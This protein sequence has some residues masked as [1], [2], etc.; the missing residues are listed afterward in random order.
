MRDPLKDLLDTGSLL[1]EPTD[2]ELLRLAMHSHGHISDKA[3][4]DEYNRLILLKIKQ[5]NS[6]WSRLFGS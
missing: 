2:H 6:L 5:R 4:I 3:A 1:S